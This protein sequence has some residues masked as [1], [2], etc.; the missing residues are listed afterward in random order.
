MIARRRF[1]NSKILENFK[2]SKKNSDFD[3]L[4]RI[5]ELVNQKAKGYRLKAESF[6]RLFSKLVDDNDDDVLITRLKGFRPRQ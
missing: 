3:S 1:E 6:R 4:K 5:Q 2:N